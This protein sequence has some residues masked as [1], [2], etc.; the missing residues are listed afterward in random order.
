M[1]YYRNFSGFSDFHYLI[2][3]AFFKNN[4]S[5][6]EEIANLK[7]YHVEILLKNFMKN[8]IEEF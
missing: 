4:T 5:N 7:K 3:S 1:N 2:L 6:F 8:F